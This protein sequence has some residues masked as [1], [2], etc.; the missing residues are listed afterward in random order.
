MKIEYLH[1]NKCAGT[2][3]LDWF[4]LN[5]I[6]CR[7]QNSDHTH[8]T[9]ENFSNDKIYLTTVRNPYNRC[10]SHY[11]Q[12]TKLNW[13]DTNIY[14]NVNI[15]IEQFDFCYKE[16]NTKKLLKKEIFNKYNNLHIYNDTIGVKMIYPCSWWIKD[17]SKYKIFKFEQIK[18]IENF[19]IHE[20]NIKIKHNLHTDF[21]N[22]K[23]VTEGKD[24]YIDRLNKTS[25]KII[26]RLFND[27]FKKFNYKKINK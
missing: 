23:T 21:R 6:T 7:Y 27:D 14:P 25:I 11:N 26:N 15:F 3:I 13:I 12:W 5:N 19:F 24:S 9:I 8:K 4:K 10:V 20:K 17:F 22:P 1:I 16:K 18:E 2:S